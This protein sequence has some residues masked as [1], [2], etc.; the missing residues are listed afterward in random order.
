[1]NAETSSRYAINSI[2]RA[3]AILRCLAR[4]NGGLRVGAIA[5]RLDLDR[6]TVFRLIVTLEQC[7]FVERVADTK[8][9]K[10]GVGVFEIGSAYLRTTDLHSVARP[11]MIELARGV[12]EAV[13]WAILSADKAVCIDKIDSPRGL[14]TTSKIG[15]AVALNSGSV[16][17]VL[18]AFQ[19]EETR[20]RLLASMEFPRFTE[21]TITSVATLRDEI[22]EIRRL[23]YCLS[24]G[25]GEPDMACA[26][27][28]IFDHNHRII[29][30]LSIG[31]SIQRFADEEN[32]RFL[33]ESLLGAARQISEKMGCAVIPAIETAA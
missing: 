19:T 21:R 25:E 15:G 29:A 1:M 30:G 8:E 26:A 5:H 14:G 10:L 22:A 20:D 18:L 28:P 24:L 23:G 27:A 6:T 17:K 9:I 32:A 7:G 12:K 11:V 31:G 13:H 3:N 16:G 2:L 4:E 33:V